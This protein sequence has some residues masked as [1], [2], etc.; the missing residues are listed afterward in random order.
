[1]E[2]LTHHSHGGLGLSWILDFLLLLTG[3]AVFCPLS[4]VSPCR[5]ALTAPLSGTEGQQGVPLS[6][7]Q[8]GQL[9]EVK[10]KEEMEP[11]C[12]LKHMGSST[13]LRWALPHQGP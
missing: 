13:L 6:K 10:Q 8:R 2:P 7:T 1:M 9:V 4:P 11:E 12:I 5:A 3:S